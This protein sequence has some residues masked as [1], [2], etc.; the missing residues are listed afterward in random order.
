MHLRQR[1]TVSG[2]TLQGPDARQRSGCRREYAP[3]AGRWWEALGVVSVTAHPGATVGCAFCFSAPRRR[4]PRV[5]GGMCT[6][7]KRANRNCGSWCRGGVRPCPAVSG[8]GFSVA[9]VCPVFQGLCAA[10]GETPGGVV[11]DQVDKREAARGD[12]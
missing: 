5:P 6:M 12:Q 11:G 2:I 1:F 8:R 4:L 9:G 3:R 7:E 10:Q